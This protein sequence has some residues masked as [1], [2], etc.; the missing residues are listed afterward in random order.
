MTPRENISVLVP[1]YIFLSIISGAI[2]VSEPLYFVRCFISSSAAYPKSTRMIY[3]FLSI[4][5]FSAFKSIC[6]TPLKLCIYPITSTNYL[7]IYLHPSSPNP[8]DTLHKLKS[9]SLVLFSI[10]MYFILLNIYPV[11]S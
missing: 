5:I 1:S 7:I 8:F 4:K 6:T 11:V 10:I 3:I 9:D 2:Y